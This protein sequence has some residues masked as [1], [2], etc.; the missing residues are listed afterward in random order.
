MTMVPSSV[1]DRQPRLHVGE[2][3]SQQLLSTTAVYRLCSV[4]GDQVEVEVVEAP[5]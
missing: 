3:R 5:A 2:V 4:D 1:P